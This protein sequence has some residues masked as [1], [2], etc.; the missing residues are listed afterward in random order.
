MVITKAHSPLGAIEAVESLAAPAELFGPM[1]SGQDSITNT[2]TG[3]REV[4]GAA[5]RP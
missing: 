3:L 4:Y 5:R 1:S 2:T